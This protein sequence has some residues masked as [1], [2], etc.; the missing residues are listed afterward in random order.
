MPARQTDPSG[1]A[2]AFPPHTDLLAAIGV[3]TA[4]ARCLRQVHSRRVV[5]VDGEPADDLAEVEADGM[6]TA[7]PDLLLTVTVADCLPVFLLDTASGAFGIVHSGWKGTGIVVDALRLM[8]ARFGTRAGQVAAAIGP[9]IGACCYEVPAED[10]EEFRAR[11]GPHAVGRGPAA[12]PAR[13]NI[14]LLSAEGVTSISV[15]EECTCCSPRLGSYRR[16][17][18]TDFSRMLAFIGRWPGKETT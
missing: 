1:A 15:V 9:G 5:V 7:R 14:A 4:R 13:A 8:A 11:F 17:G 18:A 16:Q 3:E 6:V 12:G 10:T 2:G